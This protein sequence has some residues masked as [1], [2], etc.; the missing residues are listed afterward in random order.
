MKFPNSILSFPDRGPWG[1]SR[2]RGNCSGHVIQGFSAIY[3]RRKDGLAFDPRVGG[4]TSVEVAQEMGLRFKGTDLLGRA[5]DRT[6][7][8]RGPLPRLE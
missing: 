7:A 2:Y 5:F 6:A 8:G 1:N 4:G 3:H